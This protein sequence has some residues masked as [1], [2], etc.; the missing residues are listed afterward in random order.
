MSVF[1]FVRNSRYFNGVCTSE[2]MYEDK[3]S[4]RKRLPC[5]TT[6]CVDAFFSGT[7][8]I[9]SCRTLVLPSGYRERFYT[10]GV[11]GGP[12]TM[13]PSYTEHFPFSNNEFCIHGARITA[14]ERPVDPTGRV[15]KGNYPNYYP[16]PNCFANTFAA[17]DP[18]K[19]GYR[20]ME[21]QNLNGYQIDPTKIGGSYEP[22]TIFFY[23]ANQG[24]G[25]IFPEKIFRPT[26]EYF[27]VGTNASP[28]TS[29][30]VI[31]NFAY[32]EL[33]GMVFPYTHMQMAQVGSAAWTYYQTYFKNAEYGNVA[34]LGTTQTWVTGV[35]PNPLL[36]EYS[37]WSYTNDPTFGRGFSITSQ[38]RRDQKARSARV[39][40][41]LADYSDN[42]NGPLIR[43]LTWAPHFHT[44]YRMQRFVQ[45]K[46][47]GLFARNYSS[48][49]FAV[50][51]IETRMYPYGYYA[52]W[53]V[54]N[55]EPQTTY[56]VYILGDPTAPPSGAPWTFDW[57][58]RWRSIAR[59]K[60]TVNITYHNF[61]PRVTDKFKYEYGPE[62]LSNP[63]NCMERRLE[64]QEFNGP[65]NGWDWEVNY[66][67]FVPPDQ[68]HN[69][70]VPSLIDGT[71]WLF[72][73]TRNGLGTFPWSTLISHYANSQPTDNS[74]LDPRS[75]QRINYYTWPLTWT[76]GTF[77][78]SHSSHFAPSFDL[79]RRGYR[80]IIFPN[81]NGTNV[82]LPYSTS[83]FVNFPGS[84]NN[85]KF[86]RRLV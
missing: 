69:I 25:V 18:G 10:W 19:T 31:F 71:H 52:K 75:Q 23:S 74:V 37:N 53:T 39:Y 4:S 3:D 29:N 50:R 54:K 11:E 47:L 15:I 8:P 62:R 35:H 46:Q 85:F 30:D 84:P 76:S 81:S 80:G 72:T 60:I 42:T 63:Y 33:S 65:I 7:Q 22:V 56:G 64:S 61:V 9:T 21:N 51:H 58:A 73:G 38:P 17:V 26:I 20:A 27:D 14:A 59:G 13:T 78:M 5:V 24:C 32:I 40:H 68:K 12:W 34:T 44:G 36:S 83:K 57:T 2:L 86:W 48:L 45:E 41:P 28:P 67:N 77:P 82:M 70:P 1:K 79:N 16:D 55:I 43:G 6:T 49:A 66:C